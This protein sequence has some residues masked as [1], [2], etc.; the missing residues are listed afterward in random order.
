MSQVWGGGWGYGISGLHLNDES[1]RTVQLAIF[2]VLGALFDLSVIFAAAAA[3]TSTRPVQRLSTI[4]NY[5]PD[6]HYDFLSHRLQ[7]IHSQ[8]FIWAIEMQVKV[9]F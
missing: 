5:D 3:A 1:I 4:A 9:H 8:V 7:A 2:D 6:P